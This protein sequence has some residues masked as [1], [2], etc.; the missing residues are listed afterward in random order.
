MTPTSPGAHSRL[1]ERRPVRLLPLSAVLWGS[2]GCATLQPVQQPAQF[3]PSVKPHVVMVTYN[4]N[5][6]VPFADPHLS[7]D[8]LVGIWDGLGEPVSVALT[9]VQ[10]IDAMQRYLAKI[11][12]APRYEGRRDTTPAASPTTTPGSQPT[13][14]RKY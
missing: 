3:I 10:R 11:D 9:E 7:G 14:A 12:S 8:T 1:P 5:S 6:M 2:V 13:P 4:D